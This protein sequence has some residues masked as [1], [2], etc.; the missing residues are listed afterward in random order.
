MNEIGSRGTYFANGEEI[1]MRFR[2]ALPRVRLTIGVL[3]VLCLVSADG[4]AQPPA[5]PI[6]ST[7]VERGKDTFRQ[8]CAV[9]HGERGNGKGQAAPA[10]EPR[11]GDL[12]TLTRRNGTFPAAMVEAT[13]KATDPIRAHGTPGM[14]VWGALF[15]AD[16]NGSQREADA[17][18][19]DVV[20]F[21]ESIQAK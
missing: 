14:L 7:A 4:F 10:L 8:S 3:S 5:R 21:I 19:R 6:A 2:A 11:P 13:I 15:L 17:R 18:I 20:K 1:I 9:C 12:T 16:A